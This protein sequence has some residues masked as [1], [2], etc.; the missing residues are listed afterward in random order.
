MARRIRSVLCALRVHVFI[1]AAVCAVVLGAQS[2]ESQS[3]AFRSRVD[4]VALSVTVT[5]SGGRYVADLSR[6]DFQIAEDG[7]EQA[8]TFFQTGELRLAL[9]LLM[10]TSAS[11]GTQLPVAQE[12][13]V[14]FV[15]AL[16]AE[17]V[18]SV[19]DFDTSVRIAQE[20]TADRPALE[21]AI[22]GTKADGSTALYNALY[23]ALKELNKTAR[24]QSGGEMRRRAIVVLS[25]GE[26]TSSMM[27]F[28]DLLDTAVRADT[29]IYTIGLFAKD[30]TA[31][32]KN[33][34]EPQFLLRRLAQQTGG[35]AFFI[36]DAKELSAVYAEIRAELANQYFLAYESTNTRRDGQYRRVAV[37]VQKPDT[38]VRTRPGY[39]APSR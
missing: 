28:D 35:R 33:A 18:A 23:V 39:Y 6:E 10:D 8:V 5:N 13:A 17:D 24:D 12:A 34:G 19:V 32:P 7:R 14:G 9:A 1:L 25:D 3:T 2:A 20:F 11:M 4:T 22:R 15:R 38:V 29:S 26:D 27:T 21:K 36:A 31:M 16:G 30:P 37:R